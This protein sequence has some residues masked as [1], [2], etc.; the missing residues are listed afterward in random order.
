MVKQSVFQLN[1]TQNSLSLSL[2]MFTVYH[3]NSD[4]AF[5]FRLK[6]L[7]PGEQKSSGCSIYL[8]FSHPKTFCE[9]SGCPSCFIQSAWT[10]KARRASLQSQ[11]GPNPA[12][13]AGSAGLKMEHHVFFKS[14][15]V[16]TL[17]KSSTP[18]S[19]FISPS[20]ITMTA[21][22]KTQWSWFMVWIRAWWTIAAPPSLSAY[23]RWNDETVGITQP[24]IPSVCGMLLAMQLLCCYFC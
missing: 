8:Y 22:H 3:I 21:G 18:D 24:F 4:T 12:T 20:G 7:L 19:S 15:E 9:V 1:A 14:Y 2:G 11:T 17:R 5:S 16:E 13:L 10:Q 23:S 6:V